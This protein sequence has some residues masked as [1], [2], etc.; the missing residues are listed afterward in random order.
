MR[1]A[2]VRKI[3]LGNIPNIS[4]YAC[5]PE[6]N[7]K[8]T[9]DTIEW[10]GNSYR[11]GMHYVLHADCGTRIRAVITR[12]EY[13]TPGW[14]YGKEKMPL[15]VFCPQCRAQVGKWGRRQLAKNGRLHSFHGDFGAGNSFSKDYVGAYYIFP[16]GIGFNPE[17]EIT[18]VNKDR[19]RLMDDEE[20]EA[21]L[22]MPDYEGN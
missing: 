8:I 12:R 5:T 22:D 2:E 4:R 9:H 16:M 19:A 7:K 6:A 20:V 10:E 13:N 1:L 18:S 21:E 14:R 15:L 17:G 3:L 11:V